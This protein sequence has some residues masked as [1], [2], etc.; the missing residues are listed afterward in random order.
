MPD[1]ELGTTDTELIK[2]LQRILN[3]VRDTDRQSYVTIQ[4]M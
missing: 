4:D 1:N 3:L 2:N